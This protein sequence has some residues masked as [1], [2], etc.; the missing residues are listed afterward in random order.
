MEDDLKTAVTL[1][2]Y[3]E[4]GPWFNPNDPDVIAGKIGTKELN[5]KVGYVNDPDDSGGET[6]FGIS[7][8]NETSVDIKTLDLAT[9]IKIYESHYWAM[10]HC[11]KLPFPVN[12]IHMD[13]AV[14]TG[15]NRATKMLQEAAKCVPVDGSFGPKTMTT[16]LK[17]DPKQLASAMLDIREQFYRNLVA[18]KPTQAKF[19]KGWLSRVNMLRDWLVKNAK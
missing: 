19:L 10:N 12:I 18:Q 16:V 11:D 15:C 6:K 3:S 13:A 1:V 8:N 5:K 17:L 7:H 4:V 9:A 2:M 14:N